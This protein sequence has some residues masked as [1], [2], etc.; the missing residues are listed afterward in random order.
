[1]VRPVAFGSGRGR[2]LLDRT[3]RAPEPEHDVGPFLLLRFVRAQLAFQTKLE[4]LRVCPLMRG[5]RRVGEHSGDRAQLAL[6]G[7]GG[8][9]IL[10][11]SY[12]GLLRLR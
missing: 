2:G 5:G 7:L 11:R 1:M 3:D 6:N 4:G 8:A 10:A 12:R 9:C